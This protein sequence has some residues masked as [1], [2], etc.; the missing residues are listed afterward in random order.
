VLPIRATG[1]LIL[2]ENGNVI[3]ITVTNPGAGYKLFPVITFSGPEVEF[4]YPDIGA[5][6][7]IMWGSV[8]G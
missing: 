4:S 3:G 5:K 2:D 1:G 7:T 8:N 6:D